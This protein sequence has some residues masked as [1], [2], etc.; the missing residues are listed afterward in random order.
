MI[1]M[2]RWFEEFKRGIRDRNWFKMNLTDWYQRYRC[3]GMCPTERN[4][5]KRMTEGGASGGR[6]GV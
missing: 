5:K 2:L 4:K 1:E 3:L 6:G